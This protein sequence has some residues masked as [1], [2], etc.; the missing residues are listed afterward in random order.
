MVA[1]RGRE[2][3]ALAMGVDPHAGLGFLCLS[4]L[5][6]GKNGCSLINFLDVV[7]LA[8]GRQPAIGQILYDRVVSMLLYLFNGNGGLWS[9]SL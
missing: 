4:V 9:M 8:F 3:T 7:K 2:N 6:M 1:K 5:T